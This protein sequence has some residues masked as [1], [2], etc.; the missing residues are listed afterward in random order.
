MVVWVL[1]ILGAYDEFGIARS[2]VHVNCWVALAGICT[3]R[4][5]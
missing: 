1:G 4:L 5:G 3:G 2:V